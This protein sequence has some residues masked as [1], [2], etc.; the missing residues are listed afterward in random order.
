MWF[1]EMRKVHF[2]TV[3]VTYSH[4][5]SRNCLRDFFQQY[6]VKTEVINH[7]TWHCNI[8][9]RTN[10]KANV[11]PPSRKKRTLIIPSELFYQKYGAALR[12]SL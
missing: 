10:P 9:K 1:S 7:A 8:I 2:L 4:K 6:R 3:E 5:K 11:S 12:K